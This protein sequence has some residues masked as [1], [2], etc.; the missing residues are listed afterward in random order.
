MSNKPAPVRRVYAN[1]FAH[2]DYKRC[3]AP[4]VC[5]NKARKLFGLALGAGSA[6]VSHG[7]GQS[8]AMLALASLC[9]HQ[10]ASFTYHTRPLPKWLRNEP[11]GN[12]RRALDLGMDLT[13][14]SSADEYEAAIANAAEAA[15]GLFVPQGA[16]WPGAEAGVQGLANEIESWW[17][18]EQ[19]SPT[20][21]LSV[22]VPAGTGTTALY[23]ARHAPEFMT[24]FAVPCVGGASALTSQMEALDEQSGCLRRFPEVLEPPEELRTPFASPSEGVLQAWKEAEDKHNML[25]DLVYGSIAWGTLVAEDRPGG[26]FA[27]SSATLYVHCGG[28]EGLDTSLKRYEREGYL[29]ADEASRMLASAQAG[30]NEGC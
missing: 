28:L 14:H 23:L 13:E 1:T 17:K 3:I 4:G 25:V 7:G 16:A 26:P 11:V 15:D 20:A 27:A 21:H 2:L 10:G 5:G 22:V 12:L 8:N 9:H 18:G 24:V 19:P 6:V 29:E 30:V